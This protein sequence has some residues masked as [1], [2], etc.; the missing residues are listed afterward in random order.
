MS[1]LTT[2]DK[3]YYNILIN[4]GNKPDGPGVGHRNHKEVF[5]KA[6]LKWLASMFLLTAATALPCMA[7]EKVIN[8]PIEKDYVS[9]KFTL[10]F[11]YYNDYDA[12]I[13]SPGEKPITYTA[14]YVGNN[15]MEC[16][17]DDV[18]KGT[19]EVKI[20]S[21]QPDS[22]EV[23]D[24]SVAQPQLDPFGNPVE[25][26]PAV[27]E[28]GNP[29]PEYGDDSEPA[30]EVEAEI[31]PVKVKVE[32]SSEK[33][34]DVT[35]DITVAADI[36]GLK[37]YFKDDNFVAEWTDT[38]IGDVII[39]VVNTKNMQ[40]L[41][42]ETVKGKRFELPLSPDIDEITVTIAPA[43]SSGVEGAEKS[44]S[45][46]FDNHPDA[47][48]AFEDITITNHDTIKAY[49]DLRGNYG[50]LI[51]VNGK[52]VE[53]TDILGAGSY[54][55]DVPIDVGENSI[56]VYIVDGDGNM[57]STAYSVEKDVVA[58]VLRLLS[59]YQDIRTMDENIDIEGS[60]EDYNFLTINDAPVEVEMDH[61]F[62][63]KYK[64]KEGVNNIAI[65][66]GDE[67]GN[68][69]EYDISIERYVPEDEPIPWVKIIII[70]SVFALGGVYIYTILVKRSSGGDDAD[71]G[72]GRKKE[73]GSRKQ[74]AWKE[75]LKALRE[76]KRVPRASGEN[77][78]DMEKSMKKL[79]TSLTVAE[80]AS[81]A[82]PVVA[83]FVIF[84][85][86]ILTTVTQSGSMEPTIM[87]GNTVFFNRLGYYKNEVQ[88]GD[89]I[90]FWN[91]EL[92]EHMSK[93]VLGV[94]GDTIC[95]RDGYVVINGQYAD[96][97]AYLDADVETN[98]LK[99]FTVPDGYVFVLGD[100]RMESYDSRYWQNPYI[101]LSSIEG[102]FMGQI[103]FSFEADVFHT[104]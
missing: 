36:V 29:L 12:V 31:S 33:I 34:I 81:I 58:P 38:S 82:I 23:V 21:P 27:D 3:I 79:K 5:M 56:L 97:S 15:V 71:T 45:F 60:V 57:R 80:I 96:E 63:Y 37:M 4:I 92:G 32:G 73:S 48:V 49:A 24:D 66:A 19:W 74:P 6:V 64:L 102:V 10:T 78:P 28:F 7:A 95:F 72:N 13:K 70:V 26:P 30:P 52:Q 42:E 40:K 20:T 84:R 101:P 67:A 75:R 98:C 62:K 18:P 44:Y 103:D 35:K 99:V 25:L 22:S 11:D 100:N 46:K 17:I 89:V 104:L 59:T 1:I 14:V 54:E 69:A 87:T 16:V 53:R 55:Y 2:N 88:R 76:R 47:S 9:V 90:S 51:E 8:V 50:V 39:S 68:V 85:F 41:A 91:S 61:T 86:V 94:G 77:A 83:A 43:V 65:I 93:R